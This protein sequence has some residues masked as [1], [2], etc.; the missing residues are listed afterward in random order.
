MGH[1]IEKCGKMM[2]DGMY[3]RH[4]SLNKL[5]ICWIQMC[6]VWSLLHDPLKP[7]LDVE[8]CINV[9]SQCNTEKF[10]YQVQRKLFR[11]YIS[12]HCDLKTV[13]SLNWTARFWWAWAVKANDQSTCV[14][15]SAWI[16]QPVRCKV[17]SGLK[18]QNPILA[19][20]DPSL[21]QT[22]VVV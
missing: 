20:S 19:D 5:N 1:N 22:M 10:I 11:Q 16:D 2:W 12:H 6:P 15:S 3:L 7:Q 4:I 18:C 17:L 9:T 13:L 14:S 8:R 21:I